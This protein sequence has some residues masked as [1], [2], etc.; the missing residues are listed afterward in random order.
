M[1][2]ESE[3][4]V[5]KE[6]GKSKI[7]FR[8][9]G[10]FGVEINRVNGIALPMIVVTVTQFLLRVS[11]MFMLGHLD[12]LSLSA[13]SIA[14]SLCNVTGFSVVFG[15]ASALETLCGQAYGAEQYKRVGALTSG[16]ILCLFLVCLPLYLLFISTEKLLLITGQ[17]HVISA[18]A[19]KFA[20]QLVPTLLPY[21][22]LQCLVRYL[23]SQSLIF[24]MV[25]SSLASLCL[26]LPLCWAL[27][28]KFN[29]GNSGAALS[30]GISYWFNVLLLLLYVTY[31]PA[32][33]RTCWP[34]TIADV[35]VS[36]RD[37]FHLAIPSAAMVCL[38][39]WSFELILLLS[40]LLRNPQLETSVLSICFTISYLHYHIPYSFGAA[41]S[42]LISNELGSGKPEAARATVNAV[43]AL[44]IAEFI[45]ASIGTLIFGHLLGYAFSE[46]EDVTRYVEAMAPFLAISIAMDGLQ[47]VLSGV[48]RGAGW[49][50]IGAYVNLGAYYLVCIPVALLLAFVLHLKGKGLWSGL[51]AGATVQSIAL[52]VITGFTDWEKQASEAR[53]RIF[54]GNFLASNESVCKHERLEK[55]IL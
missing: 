54:S 2:V 20:I 9:W 39:W 10:A 17:D 34:F 28:F 18:E 38:E 4:L 47:S 48:A 7:V 30:I 42:T 3:R 40:G 1:E 55:T 25:W 16:A 13:A 46:E 19:G 33:R 52:S 8:R 36:M 14:T 27:I 44:S 11:P 35:L 31:S 23:Q 50:H 26:Q 32:C 29:L 41:A 53:Q 15:M 45:I 12:Q 22:I 21:A 37:F 51:V 6:K 5:G 24:P 43:L 49:Q